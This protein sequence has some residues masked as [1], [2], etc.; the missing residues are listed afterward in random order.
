[1]K[2]VV[3]QH[4]IAA[5]SCS[6]EGSFSVLQIVKTQFRSG[7]AQGRLSH[8]ALLCIERAYASKKDAEKKVDERRLKFFF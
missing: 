4:M 2:V 8:V 1:M 7:M 6:A 3:I 5:A